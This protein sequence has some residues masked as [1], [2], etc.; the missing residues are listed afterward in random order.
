MPDWF[1]PADPIGVGR[2]VADGERLAHALRCMV[3]GPDAPAGYHL[4]ARRAGDEVAAT[5]TFGPEHQGAPYLAHGGAVAA[6]C[7]DLLGHVLAL[8]N[9]PAVTGRLEV[10]YRRPVAL[11]EPLRLAARLDRS[12]GRKLWLSGEGRDD[13]D[14]V[15]FSA[16]GLFVRVSREHFLAS[17]PAEERKRLDS[18][19]VETQEG[20]DVAAW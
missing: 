15:R 1:D 14:T 17:L 7:D 3:C 2:P 20:D 6:V 10:D 5:F 13:Y 18:V 16:R 19:V 8:L 4:Q 9:T 11:G 12:E